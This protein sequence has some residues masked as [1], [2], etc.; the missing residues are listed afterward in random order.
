VIGRSTGGLIT[1][2]ARRFPSRVSALVLLEPAL[3]AL[4]EQ[5][6]RW[7]AA[8]CGAGGGPRGRLADGDHR[9]ARPRDVGVV[10]REPR[11]LFASMGPGGAGRDRGERARPLTE[12]VLSL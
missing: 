1:R 7:A 12:S 9:G 6:A 3:F 8:P 5:A 10:P 4:D 11:E 2:P